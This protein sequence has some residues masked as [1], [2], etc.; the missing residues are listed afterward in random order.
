MYNLYIYTY[1]EII[2]LHTQAYI[3]FIKLKIC[4]HQA[5]KYSRGIWE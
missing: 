4:N 5:P 3:K 2:I 1:Y